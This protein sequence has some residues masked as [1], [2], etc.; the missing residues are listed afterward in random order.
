MNDDIAL[1]ALGPSKL[2]LP[3]GEVPAYRKR[4]YSTHTFRSG[5]SF[6]SLPGDTEKRGGQSG[7]WADGVVTAL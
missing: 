2:S 3:A 4:G 7:S 6:L 1:A 5:S